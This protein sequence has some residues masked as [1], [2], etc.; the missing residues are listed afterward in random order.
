ME[1]S[2]ITKQ[3]KSDIHKE[4]HPII[5]FYINKGAKP[6][7]LK[8]YYK[9]TKRFDD[10]IDDIRNK[11]SHL[12]QDENDYKKLVRNMLNDMLDDFIS[13]NKD[14]EYK[15]KKLKYI[16]EFNQFQDCE[17]EI[18]HEVQQ[19]KAKFKVGDYV[20]VIKPTTFLLVNTKYQI[21]SVLDDEYPVSYELKELPDS[22]YTENRF[23]PEIDGNI[24]KY[25]L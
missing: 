5:T 10:L 16:K 9:N 8:K 15:N 11:G 17:D 19:K 3:A 22:I 1:N 13:K 6:E 14:D 24:K 2:N 25:N 18:S 21:K 4:L 23:I 20:Y 7:S 12:I